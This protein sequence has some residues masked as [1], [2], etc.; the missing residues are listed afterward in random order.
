MSQLDFSQ[1][2]KE[3]ILTSQSFPMEKYESNP[4]LYSLR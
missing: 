4:D 1:K 3:S 2:S